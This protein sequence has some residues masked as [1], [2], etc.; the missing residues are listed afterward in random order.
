M[1]KYYSKTFLYHIGRSFKFILE[2]GVDCERTI[3]RT[4][5]TNNVKSEV[6]FKQLIRDLSFM[7]RS[8]STLRRQN[9]QRN[10]EKIKKPA[11]KQSNYKSALKVKIVWRFFLW[12]REILDLYFDV[13]RFSNCRVVEKI[14]HGT[15]A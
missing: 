8:Q 1:K 15:R 11:P 10:S 9:I 14:V 13:D 4:K 2:V 6:R 3:L 12:K 7:V 5:N